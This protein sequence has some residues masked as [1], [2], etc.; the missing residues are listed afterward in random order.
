VWERG[1]TVKLNC[2]SESPFRHGI[3]HL[4]FLNPRLRLKPTLRTVIGEVDCGKLNLP[5]FFES[6]IAIESSAHRTTAPE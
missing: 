2:H 5:K 1:V 6:F 3:A 4:E